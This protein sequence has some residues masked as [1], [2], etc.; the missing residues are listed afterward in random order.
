MACYHLVLGTLEE[1][2]RLNLKVFP[3]CWFV[4]EAPGLSRGIA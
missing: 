2:R 1:V 3:Q 4:R